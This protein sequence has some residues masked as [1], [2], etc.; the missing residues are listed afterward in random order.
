MT[1]FPQP[2]YSS[3]P[4]G[5]DPPGKS[6]EQ[7]SL[8]MSK[9][10]D[11]LVFIGR[12][13]PFHNGH[14]KVIQKAAELA[15]HV[16]ILMGST[17]M[18]RSWRNPWTWQER[19]NFI[20]NWWQ[21]Q[22]K[23]TSKIYINLLNDSVYNN[24]QW[25]EEVQN[26]VYSSVKTTPGFEEFNPV[27]YAN[28]KIHIVE[29]G[30]KSP[31]EASKIVNEYRKDILKNSGPRIGLIGHSKDHTSFYL[32]LFPQWQSVNVEGFDDKRLLDA[33]W[34][35]DLYFEG[36]RSE[37][38]DHVLPAVVPPNV[39]DDLM[40]FYSSEDYSWLLGEHQYY[41]MYKAPYEHL[42]HGIIFNTTDAI[43]V[44]SGHILLIERK[45]RPGKGLLAMPGGF[46][47]QN[48][49]IF[50][51]VI[52][53]LREETGLKVAQNVLEG[54]LKHYRPFDDPNRSS[55]G[56]VITHAHMFHLKPMRTLPRVK[57]GDDAKKA[58][59]M[60]LSELNP[61]D[62]FEDHYHIIQHMINKPDNRNV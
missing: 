30:N 45:A 38:V 61:M 27:L 51:G 43:V 59:W 28:Q 13:Q 26:Q 6:Y 52:R 15:D 1:F 62:F 16:I 24:D 60:P 39:A 35:R 23:S 5:I 41:K 19:R 7:G 2:L 12:F 14:A 3:V 49:S 18:P 58:F 34:I 29:V 40:D 44:Q 53:E 57:G 25:I 55:R 17:N 31:R 22:P 42:P 8:V 32:N 54:S 11:F 46:I 21:G 33:T 9:E 37:F 4:I 47:N 20:Y 36:A 10:F 56:R 48:E 50:N